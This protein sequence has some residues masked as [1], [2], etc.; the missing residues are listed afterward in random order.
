MSVPVGILSAAH[1]HAG[2]YAAALDTNAD[3]EFVGV[4]DEDADRGRRLADEHG[5]DYCS[6]DE[7][8]DRAAGVVVCAP[9]AAHRDRIEAA[10]AAGVDVL[11]EKP[12]AADPDDAH[13]AVAA[14]EDAGVRLG[15]AMPLRFSEPVRR[16]ERT[17][18]DGTLGGVHAVTGTNRGRCPGGWF[19]DPSRSGGGA[20]VDH[21]PHVLDLVHHL[22]GERVRE[23]YAESGTRFNDIP[24]EDVNLLSMEL[25]DGT[26]ITLDGSWSRP[27]E[28]PTWGDAT[29]ELHGTDG[30][31][32][33]DCFDQTL[34]RVGSGGDRDATWPFWGSNPD[35]A[36]VADFVDAVANGREPATTGQ[37]GAAVAAVIEAAY[38]SIDRGEAV[39][40]DYRDE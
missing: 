21:S 7:L 17:L 24:V 4:A 40:V 9:N 15:V 33:V 32:T 5:T 23:V 28:W 12:L 31:A 3:A 20:V 38:R 36:L 18:D 37:E 2:A 11:C 27:D 13:T 16:V 26:Q 25:G 8:L 30:V 1:V 34:L 6:T 39:S 19:V 35:R 29:L 14:C 22:L 10:A